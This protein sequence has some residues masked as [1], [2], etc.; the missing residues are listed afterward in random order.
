MPLTIDSLE[1][2]DEKR[3]LAREDIQRMAYLAWERAG[4]PESDPLR[5]WQEA[6]GEWIRFHYV[7]DRTLYSNGGGLSP[8]SR[9]QKPAQHPAIEPAESQA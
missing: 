6:E 2:T 8:A 5:F 3:K 1:L 4:R 7:P 9:D